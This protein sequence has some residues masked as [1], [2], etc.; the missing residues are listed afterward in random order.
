VP[1]RGVSLLA[2]AYEC[3]VP[4]TVHVCVGCDVVH[5]HPSADG[6]A[7]GQASMHDYRI[8]T[9]AMKDLGKGGVLMNVGSAVVLPEVILKAVTTLINLGCDMTGMLG[10]NLDFV[11]AYRSN[12]QVVARVREI[13]GEGISLTGHHELML[14]L[15]T[16]GVIERMDGRR[17]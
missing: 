15:I 4:A 6:A 13:G 16:A 11:Q 17:G 10:V 7:I 1:N 3:D 2:T 12:Q 9:E 5:M 8:L 14:P